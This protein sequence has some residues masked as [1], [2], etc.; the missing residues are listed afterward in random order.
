V[1]ASSLPSIQQADC[2]CCQGGGGW[3]HGTTRRQS[4]AAQGFPNFAGGI[5]EII[6]GLD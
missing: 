3:W 4:K 5:P 2:H 1:K 6:C